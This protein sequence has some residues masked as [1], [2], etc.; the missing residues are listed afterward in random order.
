MTR[1]TTAQVAFSSGEIA[2]LLHRRFDYQR[3]QTGMA[4][5]RGFLP[6]RQGGFTRAPGT[7]WRGNT[8]GGD[9]VSRL[10]P[11]QFAVNDAV[12][13]EFSNLKMRVWRYGALVTSGG[14]VYE[15]TT[16]FAEADLA[17][18]DWVQS[19]DV[20]YIADGVQPVQKLSR[21]ALDNWTIAAVDFTTGPFRV[22]NLDE[23]ITIQASAVTGTITLTA[24]TALFLAGH[25][26]SLMQ[27]KPTDN[28][29]VPLWTGN[30]AVTPPQK[31]RYDGKTY[32]LHTGSNTGV[33]PPQHSRGTEQVQLTPLTKWT[34]LDDGEGVVRITA[35][36][37]GGTT[38]TADVIRQLP[39]GVVDDPTYRFAEGAWSDLYGYPAALEIVEQ[40]LAA[41]STPTDP[42]TVWFSTIGAYEDFTPGIEADS[43]FAYAISGD[44]S[45]NR[46]AWLKRGK[47]GLHIGAIGEEYSTRS[48]DRD[49][50]LGPTTVKIGFDSA[51]GSLNGIRPIAPDG[52]PMFIDR[53]GTRLI[54]ISYSFQDDANKAAELS[55]PSNHL[56]VDGFSEIVWQATP[57]RLAWLARANGELAVMVYDPNEEVLG[58][59]PYSLAGGVVESMAVS[60][61]AT[62]THDV[63]TLVVRRTVNGSTQRFIEEQALTYGMLTGSQ[64]IAEAVHFFAAMV[65]TP[66]APTDTFNLPHLIGE[67]VFA[68]TDAGEFGPLTVDG[69]GNVTL[70]AVVTRAVIGLMDVTHFAETLDL[71]GTAPDGSTMGRRRRT[72]PHVGI[73]LHRTTQAKMAT[74]ERDFGQAERVSQAMNLVPLPIAADLTTAFTGVVRT[75]L[76][77]GTADEVA[78]R[79]YP[80]GGSPMTI[81]AV[82]PPIEQAGI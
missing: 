34:Y 71:L 80:V 24:S 11:F 37:G 69:S 68:W 12:V 14:P 26:G 53:S 61:D 10:V 73:G 64:P 25:V 31:M 43:S 45:Q 75:D 9:A 22:Q 36:G 81:T 38:A 28:S 42:R 76:A 21:L 23:A 72:V 1:S 55:L 6:L 17:G 48:T 50:A 46:I 49:Q 2:P 70:G 82:V 41:A 33:N 5:C 39:Q 60:P 27:L 47:T 4:A 15:L 54:E 32:Q 59:A 3:Y 58:W 30:T 79:F 62:G 20:I 40:R 44:A 57:Q 66:G 19:A 67:D 16:P 77:G 78:L 65:F 13:L 56:G 8:R 7:I 51:H 74:V 52:K 18:L 35:I 63:L 29:G